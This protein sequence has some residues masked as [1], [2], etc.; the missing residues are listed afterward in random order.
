[1]GH[2]SGNTMIGRQSYFGLGTGL[3][4]LGWS[5]ILCLFCSISAL[6]LDAFPRSIRFQLDGFNKVSVEIEAYWKITQKRKTYFA[7]KSYKEEAPGAWAAPQ[8]AHA[9]Q[10]GPHMKVIYCSSTDSFSLAEIGKPLA[11]LDQNAEHASARRET[12]PI[13]AKT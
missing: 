2:E 7:W 4:Q 1:M 5:C 10:T 3:L 11:L 8:H 12:N 13:D 9:W 6:L